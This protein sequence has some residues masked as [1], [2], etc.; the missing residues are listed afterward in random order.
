M[1]KQE[2]D[3]PVR[4]RKTARRPRVVAMRITEDAL[5]AVDEQAEKEGRNRSDM[6]RV[7]LQRGWNASR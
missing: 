3:P 7:L 5:R 1:R 6:L 4:Q 2:L